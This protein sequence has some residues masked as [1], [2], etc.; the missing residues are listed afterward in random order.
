MEGFKNNIF[1]V[2]FTCE[3]LG[4]ELNFVLV[5]NYFMDKEEINNIINRNFVELNIKNGAN[6]FVIPKES[7]DKVLG[8]M[9][10]EIALFVQ[11]TKGNHEKFDL[12]TFKPKKEINGWKLLTD[13]DMCYI[14]E[15]S[16]FVFRFAMMAI[17]KDKY[18]LV[19]DLV[20]VGFLVDKASIEFLNS[21]ASHGYCDF[22][23]Q[24]E[25]F[26]AEEVMKT[27]E[28]EMISTYRNRAFSLMGEVFFKETCYKYATFT[29]CKSEEQCIQAIE[30]YC[31]TH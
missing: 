20:D 26:D 11:K 7:Y 13:D 22:C 15:I 10:E 27:V 5:T 3:F 1:T 24:D 18:N 31:E 8:P 17:V 21:L 30:Y 14:K 29:P 4:K 9:F 16:P 25:N 2:N 19:T 28:H 12:D 6:W 23:Y